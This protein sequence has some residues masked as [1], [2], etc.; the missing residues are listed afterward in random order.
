MLLFY[1]RAVN[2][3]EKVPKGPKV[4]K[5]PKSPPTDDRAELRKLSKNS[6]ASLLFHLYAQLSSSGPLGSKSD[7]SSQTVLVRMIAFLGMK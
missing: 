2:G 4:P 7:K 3:L 1:L 6:P 5:V